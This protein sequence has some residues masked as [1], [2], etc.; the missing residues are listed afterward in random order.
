MVELW[1]WQVAG[2]GSVDAEMAFF[3]SHLV[4]PYAKGCLAEFRPLSWDSG[5][6]GYDDSSVG[7]F[8]ADIAIVAFHEDAITVLI[9]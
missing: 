3:S 8:E 5:I 1:E 2:L 7:L 6:D 4:A 9:R